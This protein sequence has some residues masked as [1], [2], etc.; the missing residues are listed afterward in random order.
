MTSYFFLEVFLVVFFAAFF[1]AMALVTSFHIRNVKVGKN[2][3]NDFL[4]YRATIFSP[5]RR[6]LAR[7]RRGCRHISRAYDRLLQQRNHS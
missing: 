5:V 6:A 2:R 4:E 3:V 7:R 1:F